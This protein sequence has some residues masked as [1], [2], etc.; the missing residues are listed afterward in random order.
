MTG[1]FDASNSYR[2]LV[3]VYTVKSRSQQN[4]RYDTAR[5]SPVRGSI[6]SSD[7]MRASSSCGSEDSAGLF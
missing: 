7:A 3:F 6:Q 1:M 4:R 5:G 2:D